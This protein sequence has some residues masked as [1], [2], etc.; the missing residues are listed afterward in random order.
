MKRRDPRRGVV[1]VTVLVDDL[2]A[3]GTRDGSVGR[4]PRTLPA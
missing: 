3:V 4:L 2:A 1:L